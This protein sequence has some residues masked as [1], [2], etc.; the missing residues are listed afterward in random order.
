MIDADDYEAI[1]EQLEQQFPKQA[2]SQ[3]VDQEWGDYRDAKCAFDHFASTWNADTVFSHRS[4]IG[5]VNWDAFVFLLPRY[6]RACISGGS[7]IWDVLDYTIRPLKDR[8]RESG[9]R[10]TIGQRAALLTVLEWWHKRLQTANSGVQDLL[11]D[12]NLIEKSL[13]AESKQGRS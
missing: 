9:G 2:P 13:Q 3:V 8:A 4:T 7:I 5:F 10:F 6:F 1:L 12:I 11:N